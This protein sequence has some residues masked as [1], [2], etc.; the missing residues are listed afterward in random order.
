MIYE[1]VTSSLSSHDAPV[2]GGVADE[3][4][5]DSGVSSISGSSTG[6]GGN[7]SSC[8]SRDESTPDTTNVHGGNCWSPSRRNIG[9]DDSISEKW[10]Q[11]SSNCSDAKEYLEMIC[12]S[13]DLSDELT[14]FDLRKEQKLRQV[15]LDL[16]PGQME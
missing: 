5:D 10:A 11:A 7:T 6:G 14:Q 13:R 15:F 1:A 16:A 3:V 8:H 12:R 4:F 9:L 2:T